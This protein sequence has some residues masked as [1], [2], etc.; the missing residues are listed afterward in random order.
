MSKRSCVSCGSHVENKSH[1]LCQ[2]CLRW[3]AP[4][5]PGLSR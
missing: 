5:D 2:W 1:D 3:L 4:H